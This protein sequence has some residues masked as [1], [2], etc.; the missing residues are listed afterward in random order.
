MWDRIPFLLRA[1]LAATAVT[2]TAT[3]VWRMTGTTAVHGVR[4]TVRDAWQLGLVSSINCVNIL[5]D[6]RKNIDSTLN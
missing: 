6:I 4:S 2:G 3:V 5:V 1:L